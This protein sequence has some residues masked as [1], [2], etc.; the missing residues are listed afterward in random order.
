M[1][2]KIDHEKCIGCAACIDTCP[3]V[4]LKMEDD[5]AVVNEELCIDCGS[6]ISA[7]PTEAIEL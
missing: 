5:K 6:C 4:A 7:C 2:V 1:S 3:V